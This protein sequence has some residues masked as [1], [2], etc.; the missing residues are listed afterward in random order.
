MLDK[1]STQSLQR[2]E[3]LA[4]AWQELLQNM[5]QDA[6][7]Y[8]FGPFVWFG[9]AS[10]FFVV[11]YVF[12]PS[13]WMYMAGFVCWLAGVISWWRN[14]RHNPQRAWHAISRLPVKDQIPEV[15][16][17][18]EDNRK[19]GWLYVASFVLASAMFAITRME[20]PAA[21]REEL[22]GRLLLWSLL[23]ALLLV[24]YAVYMDRRQYRRRMD[25]VREMLEAFGQPDNS[26]EQHEAKL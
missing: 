12:D 8:R 1:K 26:R 5:K 18:I 20:N 14:R 24:L 11:F 10:L 13:P 25:L 21:W 4:G 22:D 3:A 2:S 6:W 16:E 17:W 9:I 7:W 19:P 23:P 15:G